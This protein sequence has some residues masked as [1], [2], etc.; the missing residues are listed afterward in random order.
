MIFKDEIIP[1]ISLSIGLFSQF[2]DIQRH[3][4]PGT[5][6]S[7]DCKFFKIFIVKLVRWFLFFTQTFLH[8]MLW[9]LIMIF[10]RGFSELRFVLAYGKDKF[11]MQV[12]IEGQKVKS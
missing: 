6:K 5:L 8:I 4:Q 3:V 2:S 12:E 9:P 7:N 11:D 10:K 1:E